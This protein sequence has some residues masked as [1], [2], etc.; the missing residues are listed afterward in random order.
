MNT[1]RLRMSQPLFFAFEAYVRHYFQ[2]HKKYLNYVPRFVELDYQI[3]YNR[4]VI[5]FRT[6]EE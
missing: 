5:E 4:K 6:K 3:F 2:M 1:K